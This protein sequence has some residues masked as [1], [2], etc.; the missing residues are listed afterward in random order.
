MGYM[1]VRESSVRRQVLA[2]LKRRRIYHIPYPATPYGRRGVPDILVC[3]AGRFVGLELKRPG[4]AASSHQGIEH[5]R[6]RSAG[7]QAAVVR[8]VADL[9]NVLAGA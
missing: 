2:E 9:E 5:E 8:S 1:T 3:H 4:Q 6:I 7:G